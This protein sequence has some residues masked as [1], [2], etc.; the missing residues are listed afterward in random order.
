MERE[1]FSALLQLGANPLIYDRQWIVD[2]K[3]IHPLIIAHYLKD[4]IEKSFILGHSL[5]YECSFFT[6]EFGIFLDPRKIIDI[7]IIDQLLIAGSSCS[8]SLMDAYKR[9]MNYGFFIAQTSR[10]EPVS[11]PGSDFQEYEKFKERMQTSEWGNKDLTHEQIWYAGDDVRLPFFV[12][13]SQKD[14]IKEH[15]SRHTT[16]NLLLR[17]K[18]EC[19]LVPECADMFLR[20]IPYD[21]EYHSREIVPYLEKK[22]EEE[23][24]K[25]SAVC[26]NPNPVVQKGT[27]RGKKRIFC[28]HQDE[29]N[30]RSPDQ[31]KKSLKLLGVIVKDTKE[32][33]L[34]EH[35]FDHPAVEHILRYKKAANLLSKFGNTLPLFVH[36]NGCIY[37]DFGQ[38]GTETMRFAYWQPNMQQIPNKETLFGEILSGLLFRR[39]FISEGEYVLIDAD[40][41]NIE[42]RLIA[43]LTQEQELLTAFTLGIDYHGF[44]AKIL[45]GL[46]YFPP[47]GSWH[48]EKIGKIGNLS[49]GYGAS[50]KTLKENM[51]KYTLDDKEPIRWTDDFAKEKHKAYF[52]KLPFVEAKIREV[53][54]RVEEAFKNHDSLCDFRGRRPIFE[55]FT[56]WDKTPSRSRMCYRAFYL[57]DWQEE[58]CRSTDINRMEDPRK[59]PLHRNYQVVEKIYELDES[60]KAK[61]DEKGEPIQAINPITGEPKVK[62]HYYNAY[63]K[64]KNDIA[65][66]AYN[67]MIQAEGA[68]ILKNIMLCI[69]K[70]LRDHGFPREEGVIL[71]VHDELLLL[72]HKSRAKLAHDLLLESMEDCCREVIV[73]V[74]IKCE[75]G[76]GVTWAEASGLELS[77][78]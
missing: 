50:F 2:T 18:K 44:T 30:F 72:V 62:R 11:K 21:Q 39:A 75:A 8:T 10:T 61:L 36:L 70:K 4:S 78:A 13:E 1:G 51:L 9:Y 54:F 31:V 28:E 16:S 69:G 71:T 55:V 27:G 5:R 58:A 59:H 49:L 43:Q 29:I 73:D 34:K 65:R 77:A 64:M 12:Y 47:K 67:F 52:E 42:P 26:P 38:I 63:N 3:K 60:G 57:W 24:V 68:L 76:Q 14:K 40:L 74:P 15:Y 35:R 41:P 6:E 37:A 66:E 53:Q 25:A 19:A 33:T 7:R 17:I 46:D 20:G 48:R 56:E 22:K 32:T 23:Y 45:M